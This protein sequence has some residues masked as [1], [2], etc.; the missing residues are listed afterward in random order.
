MKE[1]R[2]QVVHQVVVQVRHQLDVQVPSEARGFLLLFK[3]QLYEQIRF[4]VDR[5]VDQV[6]WQVGDQVWDQGSHQVQ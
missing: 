2:N 3:G 4:R 6:H 5:V 1:V